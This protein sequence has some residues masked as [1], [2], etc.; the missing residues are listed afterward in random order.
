MTIMNKAAV[1]ILGQIFFM[2]VSFQLM[3]INIKES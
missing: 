3:W 2:V 1:N